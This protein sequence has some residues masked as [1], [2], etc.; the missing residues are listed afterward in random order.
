MFI[1]SFLFV[2]TFT[3]CEQV[4]RGGSHGRTNSLTLIDLFTYEGMVLKWRTQSMR[5]KEL[6]NRASINHEIL[7]ISLAKC[8]VTSLDRR[9][10]ALD[11]GCNELLASDT[12][13]PKAENKTCLF[14]RQPVNNPEQSQYIRGPAIGL[15]LHK[16]WC[17]ITDCI[18]TK[19]KSVPAVWWK[20][21]FWLGFCQ[22]SY[23]PKA[24]YGIA[25]L[26][27]YFLLNYS[28]A[29]IHRTT[30]E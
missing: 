12:R 22:N 19:L 16:Q 10:K 20:G 7:L 21:G 6:I 24:K 5:Q 29:S 11:F 30:S 15:L 27:L 3:Q 9:I 4:L 1:F 17:I 8:D 26:R 2:L 25:V 23:I 28:C 14:Q 13:C 18:V